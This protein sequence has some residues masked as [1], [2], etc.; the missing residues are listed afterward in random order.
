M[1]THLVTG[2]CGFVGRNMVKRLHAQ[3]ARVVFIDDLS[4]GAHPDDWL[5]LPLSFEHRE[6]RVYGGDERLFFIRADLRDVLR[7]LNRDPQYLQKRYGL[8]AVLFDDI[9][10][11]AAIVGGRSKIDGD[12]MLVAQDLSIDAEMFLYVCRNKPRRFLYPSSSAAYP[13]DLQ[14]EARALQLKESDIDFKRMG[15]PDMTYGWSKL[16]GEYLARIAAGHYG[17]HVTCIRPFSG[18]GEDQDLSY[19]VPAIA[20]R[21]AR[22]ENPF[23]VWGTGRQGRDFVHIDDVLDLT[24]LAMDRIGDGR[25][26]NIGMGRLT[27]FLELIEVFAGFAGYKP[28]IK[29]LLDKP[30]G[31]HSRYCDMSWVKEHLG[32][33]P[34]ISIEEGMRRVYEAALK[35]I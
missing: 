12:P 30:V 27:T 21:A 5:G 8:N 10:H 4:V 7:E 3:G 13:I 28:A 15:E 17:V 16:T 26:I 14:T 34:R 18:Y 24:L 25:A 11:F 23:E 1:A 6:M 19:P 31:V 20:A 33:E 2:G 29:P 32:W 35:R 22:K 9:F